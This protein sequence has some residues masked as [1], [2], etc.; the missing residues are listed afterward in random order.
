[1][2]YTDVWIVLVGLTRS[3]KTRLAYSA[4]SFLA[5]YLALAKDKPR[6]GD[7]YRPYSVL[8]KRASD[9]GLVK[10]SS[11]LSVANPLAYYDVRALTKIA[12]NGSPAV[13]SLSSVISIER[14]ALET[15]SFVIKGVRNRYNIWVFD[16]LGQDF[17]NFFHNFLL[18]KRSILTSGDPN[19]IV[20]TLAE[21]FSEFLQ[22][23]S[24]GSP[25]LK[26]L[27][28]VK[29]VKDLKGLFEWSREIVYSF[30]TKRETILDPMDLTLLVLFD[31]LLGF[32]SDNIKT[33]LLI[34]Y[35]PESIH[36]EENLE[37]LREF[38]TIASN[39]MK[40]A[41][42]RRYEA[43]GITH[44]K[45]D[46]VYKSFV[47]RKNADPIDLNVRKS[48]VDRYLS[49][50]LSDGYAIVNIHASVHDEEFSKRIQESAGIDPMPVN[51]PYSV[52]TP[53]YALFE[54]AIYGKS[55]IPRNAY[56][57]ILP[58]PY[59]HIYFALQGKI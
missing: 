8:I 42:N 35:G 20:R 10:L 50:R 53:I 36:D 46:L 57:K 54:T 29:K 23:N 19:T 41:S 2:S 7:E 55:S 43:I 52:L 30:Y 24:P 40:I 25:L 6:I 28:K 4:Y 45:I 3:G 37:R 58:Y 18:Q 9:E 5:D 15:K 34:V 11:N 31:S 26:R 32:E 22:I 17:E 27:S 1:M 51:I 33:A 16:M 14:T 47:E 39:I 21:G 56:R 49:Q 38:R 48:F 13:F 59:A 12:S 44:S